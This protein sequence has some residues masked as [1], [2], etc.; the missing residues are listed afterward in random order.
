M[1]FEIVSFDSRSAD[2]YGTVRLE[3]EKK[4]QLI[5]PNDLVIAATVLAHGGVLVTHNVKEFKRVKG[6]KVE[7]WV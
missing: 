6:L 2:Y 4:G 3:L 1:P 5:G 7:D